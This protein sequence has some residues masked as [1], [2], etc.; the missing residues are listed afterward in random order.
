MGLT[1]AVEYDIADI[2]H[3]ETAQ[4]ISIAFKNTH[5]YNSDCILTVLD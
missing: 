4:I 5:G 1:H 3:G 2:E